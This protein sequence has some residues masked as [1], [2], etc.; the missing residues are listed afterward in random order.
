[1]I[2]ASSWACGPDVDAAAPS[3]NARSEGEQI[4]SEWSAFDA[5]TAR[6]ATPR[7]A[8]RVEGLVTL[9][10]AQG[11]KSGE[12][13]LERGA[14]QGPWTFWH[15]NGTVRWQGTF[16]DDVPIGR[17]RAS[18][19]NGQLHY[20]GELDEDGRT[21]L[22]RYWYDNGQ[23]ELEAEFADDARHGRCRHWTRDGAF[24]PAASGVYAKGRK[25]REL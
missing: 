16:E 12:G 7:E 14:K 22:Y 3:A 23:L 6:N 11:G 24:D 4:D 18:Y 17:E 5:H 21:G 25:V 1:L 15:D 19:D 20:E 10:N 13:R 8:A 9:W 2:A